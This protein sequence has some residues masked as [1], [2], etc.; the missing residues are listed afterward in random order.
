MV[1][2]CSFSG[3][4]KPFR[5]VEGNLSSKGNLHRQSTRAEENSLFNCCLL[6]CQAS[7]IDFLYK[8]F[9]LMSISMYGTMNH[10]I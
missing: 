5:Q 10:S 4:N 7:L 8:A 2:S 6:R 3:T 1:L 9:P